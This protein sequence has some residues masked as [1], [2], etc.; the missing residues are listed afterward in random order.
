M[1]FGPLADQLN[2]ILRR[3]EIPE[4]KERKI[5]MSRVHRLFKDSLLTLYSHNTSLTI[6]QQED[7]LF[8]HLKGKFLDISELET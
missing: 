4:L 5:V 6:N 2:E 3:L 8:S 7:Y 1:Q